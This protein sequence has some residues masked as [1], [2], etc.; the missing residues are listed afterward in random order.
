MKL[1]TPSKAEAAELLG[2]PAGFR[3]W[4]ICAG[5]LPPA[6]LLERAI[7]ADG[8][9]WLM[10]RLFVDEAAG[11]IVGSGGFKSVP[12]EN[13]VELGYNVSPDCRGRGH[14]TQGVRLLCA[15]AF[16][17][18]LVN[19]VLGETSL[20]NAASK[21]VLEKAGFT[22]CGSGKDDEGPVDLWRKQKD[23]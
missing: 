16:S 5:A 15:E 14:A 21:R 1:L 23:R 22:F 12:R 20:A 4:A 11:R 17:S 18:G 3:G 9:D 10:P 2:G 13:K 6:S 8:G 19:E 7:T